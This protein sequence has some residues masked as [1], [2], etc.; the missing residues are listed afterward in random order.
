MERVYD[1]FQDGQTL[2]VSIADVDREEIAQDD[3]WL[4]DMICFL[5]TV[6]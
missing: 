2:R 4:T 5:T 6:S 3:K 1:D